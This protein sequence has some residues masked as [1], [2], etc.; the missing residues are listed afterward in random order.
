MAKVKLNPIV[1]ELRG[2]L[3]DL[4]FREINGQTILSRKPSLNGNEPSADQAAQRERFRQA[5]AYGRFTMANDDT[6]ELYDEASNR[7]GIPAFALTVADFLNPPSIN[8]V[9]LAAYNGQVG[10]MI[11]IITTDDFG[12]VNVQV[13]IMDQQGDIIESGSAF[14]TQAN[15]GRWEYTATAAVPAG[16]AVS[17]QVTATDRPGGVA[18]SVNNKSL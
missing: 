15:T 12:V 17:I 8:E 7:K 3:G 11:K 4:V 5:V 1:D 9:D 2:Q 14:E 16:T 6:R 18:V 13:Q 10:G